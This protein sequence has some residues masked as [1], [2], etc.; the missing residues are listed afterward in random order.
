M[1]IH[2]EYHDFI[3]QNDT[4]IVVLD[5]SIYEAS[6]ANVSSSVTVRTVTLPPL[7]FLPTLPSLPPIEDVATSLPDLATNV[8]I[9]ALDQLVMAALE[10]LPLWFLIGKFMI[11]IDPELLNF[12]FRWCL[13]FDNKFVCAQFEK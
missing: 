7:G 11:N 6:D 5:N 1:T 12:I 13:G 2:H 8:A 9:P 10:S 3:V 4:E